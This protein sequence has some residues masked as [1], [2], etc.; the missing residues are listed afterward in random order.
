MILFASDFSGVVCLPGGSPVAGWRVATV[1][2]SSL[3][4][5]GLCVVCLFCRDGS[6]VCWGFAELAERL[7]L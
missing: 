4:F 2:S 5:R 3:L 6:L 1:R 7:A